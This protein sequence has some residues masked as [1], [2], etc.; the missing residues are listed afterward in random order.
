MSEIDD[1]IEMQ[2]KCVGQLINEINRDDD[3]VLRCY[4]DPIT[5]DSVDEE[6]AN[7]AMTIKNQSDMDYAVLGYLTGIADGL[8][9]HL[10]G[11]FL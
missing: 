6:T 11:G 4:G 8:N 9:L 2:K 3:T 7:F 1:R 10:G 5:M